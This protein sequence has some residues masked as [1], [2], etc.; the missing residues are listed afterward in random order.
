P[1]VYALNAVDFQLKAGEVHA[2]IGENGAGKSTL[3]KVL[4][5]IY[6]ADEGEIFIE[7]NKVDIKG[8]KSAQENGISIIHPELVLVPHMT[9]AE[10]IFLGREPGRGKLVDRLK[11]LDDAQELLDSYGIE[12]D[13]NTPVSKLTI[14]K[15]QMVEIIKAI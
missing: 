13:A 14:A 2:I 12:I 6:A 7:G 11:M 5:G 8:V 9:V 10:N 3:I 1:G 4:G 15:Q